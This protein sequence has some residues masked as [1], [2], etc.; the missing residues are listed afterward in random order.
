MT[1][2]R[3][4]VRNIAVVGLLIALLFIARYPFLQTGD[5]IEQQQSWCRG[6]TTNEKSHTSTFKNIKNYASSSG[7]E[8]QEKSSVRIAKDSTTPPMCITPEM[9]GRW[10]KDPP[11][12]QHQSPAPIICPWENNKHLSNPTVCGSKPRESYFNESPPIAWGTPDFVFPIGQAGS[13]SSK[14]RRFQERYSWSIL[15]SSTP[16]APSS[17]S[18]NAS[19]ACNLLGTRR[20]LMVGDSTMQ[21]AASTLINALA[22]GLCQTQVA[23]GISY[24]LMGGGID[25][26]SGFTTGVNWLDLVG[27]VKPDIV[28]MTVGAHVL[29]EKKYELLINATIAQIKGLQEW[30]PNPPIIVWK[31]QAPAGCSRDRDPDTTLHPL[32][33]GRTTKHDSYNWGHFFHRDQWTIRQLQHHGIPFLDMRMLYARTEAHPFYFPGW[34]CLHFCAP[35]PLD[36]VPLLFQRLLERNFSVSPCI[37]ESYGNISIDATA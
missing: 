5:R 12:T 24:N 30:I 21:Q 34:D 27:Y 31:T 35:G 23:F 32:D 13:C 26:G 22:P 15:P 18:W 11:D 17:T 10:I 1:W 7:A 2:N 20:L 25:L 3:R 37:A 33:I 29:G 6:I 4:G 19:R 8:G 28:V 14:K 16:G 36:V 9:N